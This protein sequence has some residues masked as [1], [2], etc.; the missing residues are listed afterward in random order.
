MCYTNVFVILILLILI[1]KIFFINKKENF[2]DQ[3]I[4]YKSRR[5]YQHK[6]LF[7][8]GVQYTK[9]KKHIE[10]IDPVLY[11]DVYNLSIKEKLTISNLEKTIYN[12]IK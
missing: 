1:F 4:S 10:W 12:S 9:I 3:E 11:D 8:P 2:S 5:I 7:T 6:D